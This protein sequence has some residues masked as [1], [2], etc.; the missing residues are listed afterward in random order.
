MKKINKFQ[1]QIYHTLDNLKNKFYLCHEK[2]KLWQQ[3]TMPLLTS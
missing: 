1:L 2:I 3:N